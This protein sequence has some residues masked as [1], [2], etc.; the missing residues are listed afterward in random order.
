MAP[1]T[2][3]QLLAC[4][5][6]FILGAFCTVYVLSISWRLFESCGGYLGMAFWLDW[7]TLKEKVDVVF[8]MHDEVVTATAVRPI[9]GLLFFA[10]LPFV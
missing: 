5:P 6:P 3:R 7:S 2:R 4:A 9:I 10:E 8:C 1:P